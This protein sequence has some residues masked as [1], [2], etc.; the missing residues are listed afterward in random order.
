MFL[1]FSLSNVKTFLTVQS[2]KGL[3]V[4][5]SKNEYP[6]TRRLTYGNS[7]ATMNYS[8]STLDLNRVRLNQ[9]D[10]SVVYPLNCDHGV[11]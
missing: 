4:I 10:E 5:L 1:V 11:G 6:L 3:V 2:Q 8:K 7:E 9:Y